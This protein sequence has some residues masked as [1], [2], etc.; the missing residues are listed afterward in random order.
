MRRMDQVM[1]EQGRDGSESGYS[2][3][4]EPTGFADG[5]D[6]GLERVELRITPGL[7]PWIDG[8]ATF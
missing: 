4:A 8:S 1:A 5:L 7:I 6:V 2:R 3:K